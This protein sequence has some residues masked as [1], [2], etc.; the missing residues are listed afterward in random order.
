MARYA[1]SDDRTEQTDCSAA[2]DEVGGTVRISLPN[3]LDFAPCPTLPLLGGPRE[4]RRRRG[5]GGGGL[6]H[7]QTVRGGPAQLHKKARDRRAEDRQQQDKGE[8]EDKLFLQEGCA[9][10]ALTLT[11]HLYTLFLPLTSL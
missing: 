1:I 11:M 8:A 5:H 10:I 6:R 4:S 7:Q 9:N 2:W 3:A